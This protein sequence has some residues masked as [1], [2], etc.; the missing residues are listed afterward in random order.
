MK[1]FLLEASLFWGHKRF[2]LVH[3]SLSIFALHLPLVFSNK[4]SEGGNFGNFSEEFKEEDLQ[5]SVVSK[6]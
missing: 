2:K 5:S 1:W 3:S 6:L 4:V